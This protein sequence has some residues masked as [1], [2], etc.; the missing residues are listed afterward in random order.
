[1]NGNVADFDQLTCSKMQTYKPKPGKPVPADYSYVY[2]GCNITTIDGWS[3]NSSMQLSGS[4]GYD[5]IN[6]SFTHILSFMTTVDTALKPFSLSA[7]TLGLNQ[8][9]K[10]TPNVTALLSEIK[11][12][13]DNTKTLCVSCNQSPYSKLDDIMNQLSVIGSQLISYW[14]LFH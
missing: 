8:I 1:M 6:A 14:I 10:I 9:N 11:Q 13:E 12:C 5:A 3:I 2:K 7:Y 4:I